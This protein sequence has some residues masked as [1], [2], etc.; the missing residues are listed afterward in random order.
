MASNSLMMLLTYDVRNDEFQITGNI[1]PNGQR[2]ILETFLRNQLGSGEDHA[3]P[4]HR[5]RYHITL[6]WH[7][8]TDRIDSTYDTGNK[9][10]RDGILKRLQP[11]RTQ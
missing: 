9:G 10:L 2:E 11:T 4:Q 8:N 5:D 3:E 7:P 6:T 1:N